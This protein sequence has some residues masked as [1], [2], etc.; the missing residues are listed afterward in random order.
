[1]PVSWA[2]KYYSLVYGYKYGL[3]LSEV[4]K[5]DVLK[6]FREAV[7][8]FAMAVIGGI[9]ATYVRATTPIVLAQFH[10]QAIKLQPVLDQLMPSLLPLLFTLFTYW[11]IKNKGY[12]YGKAVIV[13]FLVAFI[14]A[15]LGILG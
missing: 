1:I 13:L 12:S 3:S 15:I 11:L 9:T 4:L 6:V 14:L 5:G 7:M 2:I 10:G 8:A